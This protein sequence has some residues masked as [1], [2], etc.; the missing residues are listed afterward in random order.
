MY[1]FELICKSIYI[2]AKMILSV[3]AEYEFQSLLLKSYYYHINNKCAIED[4]S[5]VTDYLNKLRVLYI[6]LE[7]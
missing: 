7:C 4:T 5:M 3:L 6:S 2:D 1:Y